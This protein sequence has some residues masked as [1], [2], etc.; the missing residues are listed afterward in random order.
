[1]SLTI[2]CPGSENLTLISCK[3]LRM[4]SSCSWGGRESTKAFR[5]LFH[6]N[7][8]ELNGSRFVIIHTA[9]HNLASRWKQTLLG[10]KF[11]LW[12]NFCTSVTLS[13]PAACHWEDRRFWKLLTRTQGCLWDLPSPRPSSLPL[14]LPS[15]SFHPVSMRHLFFKIM[16]TIFL[17]IIRWNKAFHHMQRQHSAID[18]KTQ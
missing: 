11:L 4:G 7:F 9:L 10:A 15:L 3:C 5:P 14:A 6:I 18:T 12:P 2:G 16:L 8:N 1:M 17:N 13:P